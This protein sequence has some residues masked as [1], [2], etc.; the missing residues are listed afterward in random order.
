MAIAAVNAVELEQRALERLLRERAQRDQAR[1]E[2]QQTDAELERMR[3]RSVREQVRFEE[4]RAQADAQR[5]RQQHG[6]DARTLGQH[7]LT[8][9][10]PEPGLEPVGQYLHDEQARIAGQN[11]Y[12]AQTTPPPPISQTDLLA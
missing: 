11:A 7:D 10:Q 9:E 4:L 3:L 5:L 6:L 12:R 8:R 2:Q 1:L